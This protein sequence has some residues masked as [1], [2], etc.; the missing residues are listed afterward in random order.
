MKRADALPGQALAARL[1]DRRLVVF[2][3]DGTLYDQS[4]LRRAMA[5]RL[6]SHIALTG[7][8]STLKALRAYRH[9]REATAEALRPDFE[10]EAIAA[11]AR[12][13]SMSP[14]QARDLVTEWMQRRPLGLLARCRYAGVA[15]LFAALQARGTMVAI[16]SDY[17]A[18]AKIKALGLGADVIAF[19][20]GAG[21]ALQKPDPG[22]L[23]HLME[24]TGASPAETI[25]IG[26]R[27]DRDGQA[28]RRAGIDVL[29]RTDRPDG[30][31]T[32]RSFASLIGPSADPT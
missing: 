15:E 28:A 27:D 2:D 18:A 31:D 16:L 30:P 10:N 5:V 24:T 6:L 22:G 29:I 32:F 21:V 3:V 23:R 25:L 17:P 13:G 1:G 4:R 20:G 26:D 9:A 8:I 11:A 14:A 12:A 7:R 19:A